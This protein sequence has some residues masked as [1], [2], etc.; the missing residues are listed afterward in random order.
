[1]VP[2]D[3]YIDVHILVFNERF[4][5]YL[6]LQKYCCAKGKLDGYVLVPLSGTDWNSSTGVSRRETEI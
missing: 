4:K 3:C 6:H 2:V 1:M 5:V